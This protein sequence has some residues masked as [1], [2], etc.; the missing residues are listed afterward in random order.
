M[1]SHLIGAIALLALGVAPAMAADMPVK[2]MP[3]APPVPTWTGFYIGVNGGGAWGSV[4]PNVRDIGPELVLRL[5]QHR[6]R[7]RQGLAILPHV[8]RTLQADK[9]ATCIR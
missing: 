7:D 2:A 5:R 3:A 1:R 4:D 6:S 8:R 9:S